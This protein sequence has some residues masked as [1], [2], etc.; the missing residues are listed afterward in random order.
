MRAPVVPHEYTHNELR[1]Q[2]EMFLWFFL[3]V[4]V[5]VLLP[6]SVLYAIA[7]GRAGRGLDHVAE[8]CGPGFFPLVLANCI[9]N[10]L[11]VACLAL[12]ALCAWA[13]IIKRLISHRP[14]RLSVEDARA[15]EQ[16]ETEFKNAADEMQSHSGAISSGIV[17]GVYLA[18][19]TAA[20][21]IVP[22][23]MARSACQEAISA[24][25]WGTP[26]LGIIGYINIALDLLIGIACLV[27]GL[28]LSYMNSHVQNEEYAALMPNNTHAALIETDPPAHRWAAKL[29]HGVKK[30][31]NSS[32]HHH[33]DGAAQH[34]GSFEF[35]AP[36]GDEPEGPKRQR[37]AR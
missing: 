26:L 7:L 12:T 3:Y 18:W 19:A 36:E 11:L 27:I 4:V 23:S 34:G 33:P 2:Q 22:A 28:C 32:K 37:R 5:I 10:W 9:F 17:G 16:L 30:Q 25:S 1:E 15:D 8:E 24:V 13:K 21:V 20:L 35:I 6:I 31:S 14:S 29:A